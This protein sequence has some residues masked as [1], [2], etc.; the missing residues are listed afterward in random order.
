LEGDI[1]AFAK[2]TRWRSSP[3]ADGDRDLGGIPFT[4]EESAC[5]DAQ[6]IRFYKSR[7]RSSVFS[8]DPVSMNLPYR[9]RVAEKSAPFGE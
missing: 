8:G 9:S 7:E 6:P 2:R 4:L 1:E 5:H 3:L